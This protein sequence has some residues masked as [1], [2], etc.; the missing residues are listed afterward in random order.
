MLGLYVHGGYNERHYD[1]LYQFDFETSEWSV[2]P[3][4]GKVP[5]GRSR[6]RIVAFNQ[7][8]YML[9]KFSSNF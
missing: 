2:V 9:G 5:A 8:I 7:K 6:S 3:A 4:K 1:D